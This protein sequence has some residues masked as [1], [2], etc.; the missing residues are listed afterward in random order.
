MRKKVPSRVA[1]EVSVR[2]GAWRGTPES[3]PLH[4]LMASANIGTSGG[5]MAD[6]ASAS[7]AEEAVSRV[8]HMTS[9]GLSHG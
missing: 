6:M 9:D 3:R 1:R 4:V 7:G 8:N 5:K 2:I